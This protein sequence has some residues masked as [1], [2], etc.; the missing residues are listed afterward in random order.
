MLPN[1]TIADHCYDALIEPFRQGT[2]NLRDGFSGKKVDAIARNVIALAPVE[3]ELSLC[4]RVSSP[5]IGL[6]L[7][8]P[9]AN[10]VVYAILKITNSNL[11]YPLKLTAGLEMIA[12]KRAA[13]A[14]LT[15]IE[16]MVR[17]G[18]QTLA[19]INRHFEPKAEIL[20]FNLEQLL[21]RYQSNYTPSKLYDFMDW[22]GIPND[23]QRRGSFTTAVYPFSSL[24]ANNDQKIAVKDL[25][26][27]LAEYF[28]QQQARVD[29]GTPEETAL[30]EQFHRVFNN[31]NFGF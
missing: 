17:P 13:L 12:R 19:E 15:E 24:S 1:F 4:E 8:V 23:I 28:V 3:R 26:S 31:L 20:Q 6:L 30:K 11:L 7:M 22:A 18:Q 29:A 14:R 21:Q 5:A 10:S 16:S 2:L 27:R 9:I 25:M